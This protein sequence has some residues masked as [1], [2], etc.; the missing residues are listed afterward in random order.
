MIDD[1]CRRGGRA[2][3]LDHSDLGDMIVI[4]HGRR[5]LQLAWTH[6]LPA[7]FGGRA[8]MNVQNAIAAAGAAFAAGA[9]LHDIRQGLR[10][11]T[12]NYYLSPGRL[13]MV[14]VHGVS[15][16]VD[17]CHN[18]PGM[19]ALG[20]FVDQLAESQNATSELGKIS[21]IGMIATAGDRRDEDMVE[22]GAIA[23][24]YFDVVVIREDTSLRGRPPG[25]TADLIAA[26][27][28][29]RMAEGARCRQVEIVLDEITAVRHCMARANP[30]DLVVL[31]VDKH[32]AVVSELETL[33]HQ[34]Q[35]GAHIGQAVADPDVTAVVESAIDQDPA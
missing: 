25:Q 16:L 29:R 10:T 5:S 2:V 18:A 19:R 7:T 22:L 20:D 23:A 8:K 34:A 17:Y 35:A 13:N 33:S 12:T 24:D 32:G 1:H 26:G 27:V 31:C 14:D 21:R 30:N 4:R 11:F 28:S 6:L 9:P 15:V 3:V